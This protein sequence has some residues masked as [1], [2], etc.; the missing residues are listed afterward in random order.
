MRHTVLSSHQ[1]FDTFSHSPTSL[2]R[3]CT[4]PT[5]VATQQSG[6]EVKPAQGSSF[7]HD[8]SQTP[9]AEVTKARRNETG[10]PDRLK[11]G[12][13]S[14]SGMD[15]S[16]VRVHYNSSKPAAVDAFAYAQGNDIF[17]APGQEKHLPH[18]GWHVIQ[19]RQKRVRPTLYSRGVAINDDLTLEVEADRMGSQA[20][21]T[22][23]ARIPVM[24]QPS[25]SG[26]S[27]SIQRVWIYRGMQADVAN[28]V[29]P[30]LGN[31][32][33]SQL[34][35]RT[36]DVP[37]AANNVVQPATGGMSTSSTGQVPSHTVSSLYTNGSHNQTGQNVQTFR[38]KWMIN[39]VNLPNTLTTRNDH[40]NHVLIE[41]AAAMSLAAFRTAVQGTQPNWQRI[42][43]P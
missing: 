42:G 29:I 37:N 31:N 40:G 5:S 12:L 1:R 4:Y 27:N 18:E 22:Q 14:L 41:P 24:S 25:A 23:L 2:Q 3:V 39:T 9:V 15:L 7:D 32:S 19:Q 11:S 21:H 26:T 38:W 43:P 35:V 16:D 36:I 30:L 13:E 8:F 10:M 6:T 20:E 34:G 33:G 17:L 28:G